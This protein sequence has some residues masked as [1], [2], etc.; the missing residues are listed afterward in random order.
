M[1]QPNRAATSRAATARHSGRNI[2]TGKLHID[3]SIIPADRHY[4]W[5]RETTL[6]Q[7]DPENVSE[8]MREGYTPVPAERHPE[9]VP[10]PFPG[11]PKPDYV[12][13]SGQILMEI[14]KEVWLAQQE[15][16]RLENRE[17]LASVD[18][19]RQSKADAKNFPAIKPEL[20]SRTERNGRF[21]D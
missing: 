14:A 13:R 21:E 9:L 2:S 3:P 20:S 12:R 1:A 8:R 7:P 19:E 11:H 15:D 18:M 6:G 17:I 5:V 4:L 10:P 16:L